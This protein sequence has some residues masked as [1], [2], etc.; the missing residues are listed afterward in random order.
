MFPPSLCFLISLLSKIRPLLQAPNRPSNSTS[1]NQSLS[2][3]S[4]LPETDIHQLRRRRR[5]R[6]MLVCLECHRR[7][8][9]CDKKKPCD[10]C[11]KSYPPLKCTYI[12]PAAVSKI[13]HILQDVQP[14][15]SVSRAEDPNPH[16][17]GDPD[18]PSGV[19]Y[20]S[21]SHLSPSVCQRSP[22]SE[23]CD[24]D[25]SESPATAP[26]T[27]HE[28]PHDGDIERPAGTGAD[29]QAEATPANITSKRTWRGRS[30]VQW[31]FFKVTIYSSVSS[32]SVFDLTLSAS[33][34][35]SQR[36][37]TKQDFPCQPASSQLLASRRRNYFNAAP[38]F[39]RM[40][41]A[42]S[43]LYWTSFH[44]ERRQTHSS[45]DTSK[46]SALFFDSC[47]SPVFR[48][49]PR[50]SGKPLKAFPSPF[51]SRFCSLS[52]LEMAPSTSPTRAY[53]TLKPW[54]GGILSLRGKASLYD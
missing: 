50:C 13:K 41:R 25:L 9:K 2:S 24:R 14:L 15:P 20:Q 23:P 43:S 29:A 33:S 12:R 18:R 26:S 16:P 32:A 3:M 40:H 52:P 30:G 19:V 34:I 35:T 46:L 49:R 22:G 47:T 42:P 21:A 11:S 6:P 39:W 48:L 51:V 1:P 5:E 44:Q 17:T 54:V 7:K 36:S 45:R 8:L 38:F 53:H 31:L 4:D 28:R 27:L 37:R 10:R